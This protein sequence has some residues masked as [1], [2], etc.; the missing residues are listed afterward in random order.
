MAKSFDELVR[1]TTSKAAR[2]KAARRS[3]ELLA[4]LLLSEIRKLAGK[5]QR[6]LAAALGIRQPSLSK[7]E[8]Q[9]DMQ[10]STLMRIVEALGGRLHVVAQFPQATVRMRQFDRRSRRKL[11]KRRRV[12]ELV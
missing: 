3:R 1:R 9:D 2:E 10:I 5:S 7:L 6:E 4:E 12:L 8:H 11:K